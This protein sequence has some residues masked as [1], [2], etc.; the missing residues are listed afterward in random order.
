VRTDRRNPSALSSTVFFS[1][2]FEHLYVHVPFCARRCVYCDFS[3]AVRPDV[4]VRA[5][6][7]AIAA[8][9]HLRHRE[10]EFD[11]DTLYFGGGTPSKLGQGV[12]E[13]IEVIR[14]RAHIRKGAEVTLEANPEDVSPA[15]VAA[16]AGA[17]VNRVSLGVQSFDDRVLTWMH[18][19]HGSQ[20]ARAAIQVLREGGI[21]NVSID[22]IF[23]MPSNLERNWGR[24]IEDAVELGLPHISLYGLTVESHTPLGR[25]V[26]RRTAEEAP[27][28]RY[29]SEF[30]H[31]DRQLVGGGYEHYEVS[32]YA[33][34]GFH[35]RHNWAYWRRKRYAGLGP[36]AHEFDG[37]QRRWNVAAYAEWIDLLRAGKNPSL[38][39]E[40]LSTEQEIQERVYL[41]LRTSS[42][43][44][45]LSPLDDRFNRV[46]EAGW[47]TLTPD[48]R[49]QLQGPGW[50]RLDSIAADLTGFRSRY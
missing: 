22:L 3:I 48:S 50:L 18:R 21:A 27:E 10:S 32:N 11:L 49:L 9:L 46:L 14:S 15:S 5:Y 16:W 28:E 13:L 4:P 42:G 30:L 31:A 39:F 23:A 36:S 2:R 7:D 45:V 20:T 35:S 41:E 6:V 17:G 19:T 29:E 43:A 38:A 26:A 37:R 1:V 34:P 40:E 12:A 44:E 33:R 47:G 24:D 8:E 25:W